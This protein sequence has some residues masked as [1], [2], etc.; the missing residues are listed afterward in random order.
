MRTHLTSFRVCLLFDTALQLGE[1]LLQDVED[2][3]LFL[4]H[5]VHEFYCAFE[6]RHLG[7]ERDALG[8]GI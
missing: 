8:F 7:F 4:H 2:T 3:P 6:E 5:T 1:P